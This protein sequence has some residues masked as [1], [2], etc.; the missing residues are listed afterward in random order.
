M[1]EPVNALKKEIKNRAEIYVK[2]YS[3]LSAELGPD[4]ATELLGKAVYARG[5]DKGKRL[6]EQVGAP[7][8]EQLARVLIEGKGAIDAFG[9]E[10]VEASPTRTVLRLNQCPLVDAWDEVGLSGGEKARMCDIAHQIDF[11]KFET[12]G[13]TLRFGCRISDGAKSCDLELT[14]CRER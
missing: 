11:G 8:L 14:R 10:V 3:Q 13:Y 7:D 9:Q 5:R 1:T 4:K 12:A 2:I 6:A